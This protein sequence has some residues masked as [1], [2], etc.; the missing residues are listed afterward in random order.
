MSDID[1]TEAVDAAAAGV[2]NRQVV[3]DKGQPLSARAYA[4]AAVTAALPHIARQVREQVADE[5]KTASKTLEYDD[6]EARV[7][8]IAARIARGEQL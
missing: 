8:H 5:I 6:D 4:H 3:S 2:L 7:L 1:L